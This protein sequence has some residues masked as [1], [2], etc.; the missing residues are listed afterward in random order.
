LERKQTA[1]PVFP[2]LSHDQHDG[3]NHGEQN[4]HIHKNGE[5]DVSPLI[6]TPA[7]A[8]TVDGTPTSSIVDSRIEHE[9]QQQPPTPTPY[10]GVGVTLRRRE[11]ANVSGYTHAIMERMKSETDIFD[12]I[13]R[14]L[15]KNPDTRLSHI[16]HIMVCLSWIYPF[17]YYASYL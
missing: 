5:M 12:L 13:S 10:V 7:T 4:I 6:S 15:D 2:S 14:L 17:A 11:A 3:G 1:A 8:T 16:D 9:Q